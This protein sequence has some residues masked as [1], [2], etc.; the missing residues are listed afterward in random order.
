[1]TI[2]AS[3][4]VAEPSSVGTCRFSQNKPAVVIEYN[5]ETPFGAIL[6]AAI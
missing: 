5:R 6:T 4:K 1:M 3:D 2:I